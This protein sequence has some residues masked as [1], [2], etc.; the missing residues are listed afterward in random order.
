[1]DTIVKGY[2]NLNKLIWNKKW[3]LMKS[4]NVKF[5]GFWKFEK[6]PRVNVNFLTYFLKIQQNFQTFVI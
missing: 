1:M 2:T 4:D 5:N 6:L 3:K